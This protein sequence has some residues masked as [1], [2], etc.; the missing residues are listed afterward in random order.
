MT[1]TL[2]VAGSVMTVPDPD[3]ITTLSARFQAMSDTLA[4]VHDQLSALASQQAS[5]Q[6][7]GLAADAFRQ[8]IGRL[9]GQLGAAQESYHE[10]AA[11]LSDYADQM[12]PVVSML[13]SLA[14]QADD[15]VANLT[16][17]Q[18]ARDQAVPSV[19]LMTPTPSPDLTGL[20]QQVTMARAAVEQIQSQVRIQQSELRTLAAR[21]VTRIRQALP[22]HEKHP[23]FLSELGG[24][25][26]GTLGALDDLTIRPFAESL[27]D[28]GKLVD[29]VEL[30][31]HR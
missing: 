25:G 23:G 26:R 29:D 9:P 22:K 27:D 11:A 28:L 5:S 31:A 13:S 10:V 12:R 19:S 14:T 1:R 7:T 20:D 18:A 15:A 17:T 8:T 3:E 2:D 16:A 30:C 6:W 21:C 24:L 4:E